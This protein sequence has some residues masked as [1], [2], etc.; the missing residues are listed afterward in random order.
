MGKRSAAGFTLVEL[1]V[2]I[3]IIAVLISILLPALQKARQQAVVVDCQSRMRQIGQGVI[4]YANNNNGTIPP[5]VY[6]EPGIGEVYAFNKIGQVLGKPI[7]ASWKLNISPIF[8]DR[9][10]L[11]PPATWNGGPQNH[12]AFN[13]RVLPARTG[14]TRDAFREPTA[15]NRPW[16]PYRTMGTITNSS[17]V[18]IAWDSWQEFNVYSWGSYEGNARALSDSLDGWRFT[19][20]HFYVRGQ[21]AYGSPIDYNKPVETADAQGNMKFRHMNNRTL[22]LLFLDGHVESRPRGGVLRRDIAVNYRGT[23]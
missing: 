13:M 19:Y 20:E 1:L 16:T 14:S 12:Y 2:V 22:N 4:M 15:A 3:G 10:T 11:P 7:G 8:N 18:A 6:N 21:S 9:D 5:S 23:K 17:G